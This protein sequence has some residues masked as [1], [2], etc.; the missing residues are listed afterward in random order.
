MPEDKTCIITLWNSQ[1]IELDRGMLH[2]VMAKAAHGADIASSIDIYPLERVPATAPL[3]R[4][5]GQ[6]EW[7][8]RVKYRGACGGF[9]VGCLQR[10]PTALVEFYT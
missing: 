9:T 1:G 3:Y 10:S 7:L 8:M 6:L 4:H 2:A 5:P